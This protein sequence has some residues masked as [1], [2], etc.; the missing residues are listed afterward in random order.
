LVKPNPFPLSGGLESELSVDLSSSVF[1][2]RLLPMALISSVDAGS[3]LVALDP[4]DLL[5]AS[6]FEL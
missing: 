3:A 5:L 1:E 4:S 2:V 6:E